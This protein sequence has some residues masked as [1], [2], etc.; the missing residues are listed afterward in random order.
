M[1]Y[2][3]QVFADLRR[4]Y[5]GEPEFL[6]AVQEVFD[7]IAPVFPLHPEYEEEG[8]LERLVEPERT[9]LFR[10]P[11]VDDSGVVRVNRAFRV[12]FSSA[13]GPYKGGLRFHPTVNVS[14]MILIPRENRTPR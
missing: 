4:R 3:E 9:V 11:W 12:Q 13:L 1:S 6:Q 8:I 10:V 5:S 7:S 2:V 14:I